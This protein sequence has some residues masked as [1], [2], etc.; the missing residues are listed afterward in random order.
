MRIIFALLFFALMPLLAAPADSLLKCSAKYFGAEP[1]FKFDFHMYSR[2]AD[3]GDEVQRKGT[4]VTGGK[5][6][7]TLT[8][9]DLQIFSDGVNLWQYNP[10]QKQ[11]LIKLLSDLENKLYPSEVLFK[12]LGTN[13]IS[14]RTELWKGKSTH[15]LTLNPSKYK[16]QFKAMEV[17]LSPRDCSP[18]RLHTVDNLGNDV[19]Y[20]IDNLSKGKFSEKE[21]KFKAPPGTDEID[22]R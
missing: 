20:S 13:A 17:W 7:F 3:T 19:W 22:M 16:E 11:V 10:L 1:Q 21:F 9:P 15:A 18:L 12:Y 5:D 6:R 2:F 8:M 14:T 4:L